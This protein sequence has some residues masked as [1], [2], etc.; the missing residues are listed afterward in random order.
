MEDGQFQEVH[1]VS[2]FMQHADVTA[3][4]VKTTGAVSSPFRFH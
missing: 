3:H 2:E 1:P 4:E